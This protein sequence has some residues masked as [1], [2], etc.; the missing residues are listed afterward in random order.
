MTGPLVWGPAS[1]LYGRSR[2]LFLGF[3]IF[4]FFNIGVALAQNVWTI[5]ICR[6]LAGCFGAAPIAIV[7]GLYVDVWNVIDRGVATAA[8]AGATFLGPTMGPIVGEFITKSSLGWRWTAWITLIIAAFLGTIGLFMVP[9]TFEPVL[10][11][12][13]AERLR[14]ETKNWALH[15][16]MDEE[17]VHPEHYSKSTFPNPLKCS[18]RSLL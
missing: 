14:H 11:K 13:K 17:P 7:G 9:E 18:S 16:K 3:V 10:H 6:F 2:P 15:A 12:R 4:A 5:M 1:E 8:F